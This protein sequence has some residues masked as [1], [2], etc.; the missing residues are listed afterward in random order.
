MTHH[1]RRMNRSGVSGYHHKVMTKCLKID[2][3]RFL[4]WQA[5]ATIALSAVATMPLAAFAEEQPISEA[6]NALF[7]SDHLRSVTG[8][9][10]VRYT[11]HRSGTLEQGL[12]DSIEVEISEAAG[13]RVLETRCMTGSKKLELPAV[14]DATGNPALMCF[15]E[16]DIREMERMTGGK[17]WFFQKRI[18][19]ALADG[20]EVK[21]I[22]V[23]FAGKEIAAKEI[24]IT[25]YAKDSLRHKFERFADK[26]YVFQLSDAVPGGILEV[27]AVIPDS[28]KP[29]GPK[30][31]EEVMVFSTI[32]PAKRK[33]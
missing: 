33:R 6:E 13:K 9:Q 15:L 19:L 29:D 16:R 28:A 23:R 31:V 25:P 14:E 26:Y 7:L 4:R 8:A 10:T 24:R 11:F 21:P 20:P 3:L 12:D 2:G 32:E 5:I 22:K 1:A 30:L 18:R 27:D 17:K